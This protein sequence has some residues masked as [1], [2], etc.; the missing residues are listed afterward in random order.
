MNIKWKPTP[1]Q[2]EALE[3]TENE[4]LYG[5]SRGGG[6]TDAG[7][8]WLLYDIQNPKYR[9]LVIRRNSKDLS[10]WVDR[11]RQFYAHMN[12]QVAYNPPI[13]TFPWGAVIRTGHLN[14]A[15]AY[16]QYQG[17]EYQRILIEELTQIP[18]EQQYEMLISSCR[19]TNPELKP[20]IFCTANPGGPGHDWVKARFVDA[21][22]P[23]NRYTHPDTG[24]TRVFIPAT[25]EDNP[26]LYDNDPD[27]VAMLDSLPERLKQQWR[28]GSWEDVPVEGAVF[29]P[30]IGDI[31]EKGQIC[32][33]PF[34]QAL[35]VHTSWDLGHNDSTAIWFF[36]VY[37]KEI[38]LIDYHEDNQMSFTHYIDLLSNKSS[39]YGYTY[40]THYFPHD[41]AV[42]EYFEGRTREAK[43]KTYM[44]EKYDIEVA[45]GREYVIV[46]R[47]RHLSEAID[48]GRDLMPYCWFDHEKT[49]QGLRMLKNYRYVW[50]DAMNNWGKDPF[51]DE[52]SHAASAFMQIALGRKET[53][54]KKKYKE[55]KQRINM[56]TGMPM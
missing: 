37:G 11:A 53:K 26:H 7:M 16:M 36:Q 38:R 51:H 55:K 25:V 2:V 27:Y 30:Y 5:G 49:Y 42:H 47:I 44:K 19:S 32:Q 1:K 39:Q 46:P 31:Q 8:A 15:N 3:R 56:L 29:G 17:H 54:P 52:A 18:R 6:K 12:V 48:A 9:G 13:F 45:K 22:T 28:Y 50:N 4:V 14:D 10:D 40:G 34:E 41:F 35:P 23:G 33:V 20:Q 43:F 21:T 24:R